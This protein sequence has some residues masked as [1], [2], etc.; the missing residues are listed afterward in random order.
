MSD[1]SVISVADE[2]DS[3]QR[4][5]RT[6]VSRTAIAIKL[7]TMHALDNAA[8]ISPVSLLVETIGQG[9][10]ESGTL[11]LQI[12]GD[13][14]FLNGEVIKL[15]FSSYEAAQTLR[16]LL[17]RV[18]AQEISFLEAINPVALREFL[19]AYQTHS[20]SATP[21]AM[22][23]EQFAA[24]RLRTITQA[25]HD[26]LAPSLD[27]KRLLLRSY[28]HLAL[29][30][31]GQLALLRQKKPARMARIRRAIH[32]LADAAIENESL[33][34]GLTRFEA[35][36]GKVHFHLTATTA[37]TLLL[38]RR[39]DLDKAVFSEACLAAALHD[40]A[41]DEIP[42][43]KGEKETAE[44]EEAIRRVP[45]RTLV[46]LTSGILGADALERLAA[47]YEV[48]S[49][50][51]PGNTAFGHLIAVPCVFD[52]LTH[53]T[54]PRKG[55]LPDLALRLLFN[56]AGQRFDDRVVK[57]FG[58]MMGLYPVGSTVKLNTGEL[59]LVVQASSLPAGFARPR[60][61]IFQTAKG[62]AADFLVD[63]M[64]KGEERQIVS[65][66][67]PSEVKLNIP[68]FLLA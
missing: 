59:A 31:E 36:S 61:K 3:H 56:Q 28:A 9:C 24:I 23:K 62:A 34:M 57:L 8:M 12:A 15:D 40:F 52:R 29:I 60:I 21:D 30:I 35:F 50:P 49:K 19:G 2:G 44:E 65:S 55:V 37:L 1:F 26:A 32:G 47:T 51:A 67:A 39:L 7:A 25:E 18:G 16:N 58:A 53:P 54:P 6:L 22:L 38:M 42:A 13:N 68:Q 45:I 5:S 48:V 10:D 64:A 14:F 66:V 41:L 46:R 20:R 17:N 63:L 33:L 4:F 43:P 27:P 11:V